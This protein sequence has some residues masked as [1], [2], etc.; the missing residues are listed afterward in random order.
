MVTAHANFL[1]RD[2]IYKITVELGLLAMFQMSVSCQ[3]F[4]Q[5]DISSLNLVSFK[6][7]FE[8][9]RDKIIQLFHQKCKDKRKSEK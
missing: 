5:R 7:Y 6:L 8:F 3:Q 1:A 4:H 2:P 9:Q